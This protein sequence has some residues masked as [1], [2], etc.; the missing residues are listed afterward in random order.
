MGQIGW[1][2][3]MSL[4]CCLSKPVIR[5]SHFEYKGQLGDKEVRNMKTIV[6]FHVLLHLGF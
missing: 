6:F 1:D 2:R 5:D 3:I 4:C